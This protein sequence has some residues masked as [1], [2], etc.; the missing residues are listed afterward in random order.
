ME[1]KKPIEKEGLLDISLTG[2]R[3]KSI[4][5][6]DKAIEENPVQDEVF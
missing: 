1:E 5:D 3:I 4:D 2:L 6:K